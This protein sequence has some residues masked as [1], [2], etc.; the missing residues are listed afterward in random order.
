MVMWFK[1]IFLLFL[2]SSNIYANHTIVNV[3]VRESSEIWFQSIDP[4]KGKSIQLLHLLNNIQKK[5]IFKPILLPT[6]RIYQAFAKK[7][8]DL[9]VF[10]S[11]KWGLETYPIEVSTPLVFTGEKMF[12]LKKNRD[13]K[14]FSNLKSRHL[15]FVRGYHYQFLNFEYDEEKIKKDYL[16]TALQK[17][18]QVLTFILNGRGEVGF[19]PEYSL[20]YHF[21]KKPELKEQLLIS[22]SFDSS[23]SLHI[24]NRKDSVPSVSEVNSYIAKL[25]LLP[26]YQQIIEDLKL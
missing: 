25:K 8:I 16:F 4:P 18:E 3:G 23:Y 9:L 21:S 13:Q 1:T 19:C 2:I 24:I 11:P 12:A 10:F 14:F 7:E 15:A 17:E 26:E 6:P 20:K 22:D 5:Y